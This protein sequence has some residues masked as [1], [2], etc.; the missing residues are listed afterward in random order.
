MKL[1]DCGTTIFIVVIAAAVVGYSS[2]KFFKMKEDNYIEEIA[3]EIIE[4]HSG[5][6]VDL[7]PQSPE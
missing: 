5:Y 7:S 6:S 1:Y 2:H 4:K 3:E